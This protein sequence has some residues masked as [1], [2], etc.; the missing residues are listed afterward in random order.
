MYQATPTGLPWGMSSLAMPGITSAQM[1]NRIWGA[2]YQQR[3]DLSQG[4][5][6]AMIGG[7][8]FGGQAWQLQQQA[9][10]QMAQSGIQLQQLALQRAFTTGV[11]LNQ[12]A[13][14]VNPQ[15]G[16]PFG[17]NTGKF[18]FNIPGVGGFTSQGGGFWGVEDAFRNLNWMQQQW[19]FGQQR[20]QL[21]MQDRFFQQNFAL[22][23][24]QSQMQRGWTR[25]DWGFQDQM[26]G[27]QWGWRQEDFQENLRFMTGRER[28]LAERQMGRE[29]ILY[30][31]EGEQIDRQRK[32]QEEL[33]KL[34][35]ER[36]RI[37][38]QQQKEQVKFQEEAIKKQEQFFEARKKL[39]EEQVKIQRAYQIEQMKLQEQQIKSA[40]GYAATQLEIAKT[41]QEFSKFSQEAAAKG[42][43]FNE[44]TM[45]ALIE[46]FAEIY[47]WVIKIEEKA[48]GGGGK[49][50]GGGDKV[51]KGPRD[52][53]PEQYGGDVF[54]GQD[55]IVGERG[56]EKFRPYFSGQIIPTH[57]LDP[58]QNGTPI[59]MAGPGDGKGQI[60][61]VIN[62]GGNLLREFILSAVDKEIDV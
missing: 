29:T 1:A 20:E 49:G 21:S 26:R 52:Y 10:Q 4:L 44:D 42:N 16:Q 14:T 36:F 61:L 24:Q 48:G 15:T 51:P 31:A 41:M 39:E 45:E 46:A 62:L 59:Q 56:V 40:A 47:G 54:A 38:A 30:G 13:G 57:K 18:G 8:Q 3:T 11:G 60:R 5:I 27:M 35:D 23:M 37:Q 7:G 25:Q 19:G 33:W 34:E 43:L 22:N 12:Y 53:I 28:R 58:W 2:G 32:R 6:Q 9:Q 55:L 50:G 17:F